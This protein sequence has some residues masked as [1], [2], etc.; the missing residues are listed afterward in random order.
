MVYLKQIQKYGLLG[1]LYLSQSLPFIFLGKA[2]PVMLRQE[3]LSLTAIGFISLLILPITFKFL[4]SPLIDR[5]SIPTLG[6]YRFWIITIQSLVAIVTAGC[7]FLNLET[8]L[9][10][11]LAGMLVIAVGCASQDI[12]TDALALGLLEPQERGFG[13]AIQCIGVSLG[14]MIGGGGMLILLNHLGWQNSLLILSG[15]MLAALIPVLLHREK[16]KP[17]ASPPTQ[18]SSQLQNVIPLS[19][20][21]SRHDRRSPPFQGVMNYFKIFIR[22]CQRP[23]MPLWL[24]ILLLFNFGYVLSSYLFDL[25]L[26]D[27]NISLENVGWLEVLS[28]GTNILGSLIASGIIAQVGR[29]RSLMFACSLA[30]ASILSYLAPALGWTQ[31]PILVAITVLTALALGMV[32]TNAFTIMMDKS[33]PESAATDYA[34]Q[35]SFITL[36]SIPA[37]V[38]SGMLVS[39]I[40]YVGVFILSAAIVGLCVLL[41]PRS[42]QRPQA[43]EMSVIK[44]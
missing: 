10:L 26:V 12:A 38:V 42:L 43:I 7:S 25:L 6:H 41:V 35:A 36:G 44:A 37:R 34:I 30:A 21:N 17:Q 29:R 2:L 18:L 40:G 3:G 4:W 32:V 5:Y 13:N 14:S 22:F 27:L 16:P 9:P 31:L 11:V 8:S 19:P 33:Q 24:T 28:T 15:L 1:S 39:G 20:R 23:A